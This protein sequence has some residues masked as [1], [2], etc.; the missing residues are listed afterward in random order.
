VNLLREGREALQDSHHLGC[1][2]VH[3]HTVQLL[4]SLMDVDYQ[5][6]VG[7]LAAEVGVCHKALLHILHDILGYRK[8]ATPWAPRCN[9]GIVMRLDRICCTGTRGKVTTSLAV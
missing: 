2:H 5:W 3:S 4:A 7:K 8:I 6:A 1:P 9:S